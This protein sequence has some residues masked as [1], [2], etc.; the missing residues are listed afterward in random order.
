M[1]RHGLLSGFHTVNAQP[2]MFLELLWFSSY[3]FVW[4]F[5]TRLHLGFPCSED[6][7]ICPPFSRGLPNPRNRPQILSCSPWQR[8]V[9]SGSPGKPFL[10]YLL[11]IRNRLSAG[12]LMVM[13]EY[14]RM[15]ENSL[16]FLNLES[17]F[18]CASC[19]F[20][21]LLPW[22]LV[23]QVLTLTANDSGWH[24][25]CLED[26]KSWDKIQMSEFKIECCFWYWPDQP[27]A[28]KF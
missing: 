14:I 2:R 18:A 26:T 8:P 6:W 15:D 20:G 19:L 11:P 1:W 10:S 3:K 23:L 21:W 17:W 27:Q 16:I 28:Y 9:L 4:L 22:L 24:W 12:H 7:S 13:I 25:L 5:A